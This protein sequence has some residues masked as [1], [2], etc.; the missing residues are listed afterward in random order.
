[1]LDRFFPAASIANGAAHAVLS[2]PVT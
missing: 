2:E 1:V